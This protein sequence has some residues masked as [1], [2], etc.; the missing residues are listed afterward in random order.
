MRFSSMKMNP[1]FQDW[2]FTSGRN[3]QDYYDTRERWRYIDKQINTNP[4]GIPEED[5]KTYFQN[6]PAIKKIEARLD[7]I[8]EYQRTGKPLKGEELYRNRHAILEDIAKLK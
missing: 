5:K 1:F 4:R 3:L 2:Y 8:R 6:G 7:I